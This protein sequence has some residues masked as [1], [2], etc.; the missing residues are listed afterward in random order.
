MLQF[1]AEL[2]AT[3]LS[4]IVTMLQGLPKNLE[5]DSI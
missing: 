5:Q 1:S 3:N 2:E 4:V